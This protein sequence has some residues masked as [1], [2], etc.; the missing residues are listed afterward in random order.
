MEH[1]SR[2][3]GQTIQLLR[4]EAYCTEISWP[5][6]SCRLSVLHRQLRV[7]CFA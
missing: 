2:S 3:I 7:V 1:S 4:M 5:G 6:A